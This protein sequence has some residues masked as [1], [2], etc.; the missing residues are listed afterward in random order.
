MVQNIAP[1]NTNTT[2]FYANLLVR[3]L[4]DSPLKS[5]Q[6]Y[7]LWYGCLYSLFTIKVWRWNFQIKCI[8]E[9]PMVSW[10]VKTAEQN[11]KFLL[12]RNA[13]VSQP[14]Y[15]WTS[16]TYNLGYIFLNKILILTP[17]FPRVLSYCACMTP[18]LFIFHS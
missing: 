12:L 16:L 6:W 7:P 5:D 10:P 17:G 8:Q 14:D 1:W 18:N 9:R 2:V 3:L 11:Q 4:L 15:I 13:E